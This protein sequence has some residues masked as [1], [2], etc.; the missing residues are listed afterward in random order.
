MRT[1]TL[2]AAL[3]CISLMCASCSQDDVVTLITTGAEASAVGGMIALSANPVTAP[4]VGIIKTGLNEVCT[5]AIAVLN[6]ANATLSL[7]Q[8]L[9]LAFSHDPNL[10]KIVP[11]VNFCLPI[12][13]NISAVKNALNSAVQNI[14]P[15]VKAD[16]IAFFTGI[17]NGLGGPLT[18]E[19]LAKI[20]KD[21]PKIDG[22]RLKAAAAGDFDPIALI[23]AVT[24]AIN[25]A[26]AQK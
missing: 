17:Q 8:V 2:T 15:T 12:L 25:A 21:N 5:G 4:F 1:G 10:A 6:D 24:D 18:Q 14:N 7:Q 22:A 11:V 16:V 26:A 9:D 13:M 19:R 3:V 23:N 20:L